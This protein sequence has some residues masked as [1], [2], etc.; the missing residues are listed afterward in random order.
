MIGTNSR[1]I[2]N[3]V[4]PNER[5]APDLLGY[6]GNMPSRVSVR[7]D[8]LARPKDINLQ[9]E[10]S[11]QILQILSWG[12]SKFASEPRIVGIVGRTNDKLLCIAPRANIGDDFN[13]KG[14]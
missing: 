9:V 1:I 5:L 14:R 12:R 11:A 3:V 8:V 4:V 7:N 2:R 13:L 10:H 6:L